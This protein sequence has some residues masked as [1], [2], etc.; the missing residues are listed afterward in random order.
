MQPSYWEQAIDKLS[1]GDKKLAELIALYPDSHLKCYGDPFKTL[2]NAIVGQQIS[3]A[4]ANAVWQRFLALF[5][6]KKFSAEEYLKLK[7]DL[8]R[9]TG[10]SKQKILYIKNIANY[11]INNQITT[12]YFSKKSSKEIAE[13]LLAI[14]GIGKWTLEMFQIFYL[15]EPDIFPIG[16]IGLIKAVGNLY[17]EEINRSSHQNK[18][19]LHDDILKFSDAW[20]PYRTVATWYLWRSIDA[21]PV[22]Y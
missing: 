19:S 7:E 21:E 5:P 16:D 8:L 14:K 10:L 9:E 2:T 20:K 11:F 13:E 6:K 22:H 15:N 18:A 17:P 4:A 3:V 12:K 1:R